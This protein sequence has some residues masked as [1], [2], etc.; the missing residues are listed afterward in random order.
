LLLASALVIFDD[1]YF[2]WTEAELA[3]RIPGFIEV[4]ERVLGAKPGSFSF[5]KAVFS[6]SPL[7]L[8]EKA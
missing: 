7:N 1:A 8:R 5:M 4:M 6:T 2:H 3:S